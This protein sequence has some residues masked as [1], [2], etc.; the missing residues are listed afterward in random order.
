MKRISAFGLDIDVHA[1]RKGEQPL[2]LDDVKT[3]NDETVLY[4]RSLDESELKS[5]VSEVTAFS[6]SDISSVNAILERHGIVIIPDFIDEDSINNVSSAMANLQSM[7]DK[8]AQSS[9]RFQEGENYLLQKGACKVSGYGN[10]SGYGKTVIQI[11]DGQDSGM[12]DVF[13]ID[14]LFK[15]FKEIIRPAYENSAISN[16]LGSTSHQLQAKNLNL[17]VNSSI[18]K[19]RGF[20]VDAYRKKLKSFIY[21]TDVLSLEDG[22]YTYVR[23]SHVDSAYRRINKTLSRHLPNR[24]ETPIV[25]LDS[26]IPAIA[27]KGTLV[28]SDQGGSHRGF[29]QKQGHTRMVSVMNYS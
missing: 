9:E 10:L 6:L 16:I 28:I 27:R 8:F 7:I 12:V 14:H 24:T 25:P 22:P 26:I 29:P 1:R 11:R 20:H 18:T 13:N 19:T 2:S 23:G 15:E 21:L 4:M 5:R 17:Y 3:L